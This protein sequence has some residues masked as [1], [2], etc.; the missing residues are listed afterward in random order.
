MHT[1]NKG[2]ARRAVAAITAPALL[3]VFFIAAGAPT[4]LTAVYEGSR[5]FA[6][7]ELTIAFG[8][9]SIALLL[10]LLVVGGISDFVGRRP[11]LIAAV[12]LEVAAMAMFLAT[13]SIVGLL[14]ARIVQGV[15]TAVASS[16]FSAA[17]VELL[18]ERR[19]KFGALLTSIVPTTGLGLGALFGGLAWAWSANAIVVAWTT[20]LVVFGV[21][22]VLTAITPETVRRRSGAIRS[23]VPRISV[24]SAV[25]RLFG[26]TVPTLIGAM[27]TIALFLGLIPIV[28]QSIFD[29]ENPLITGLAALT[30]FSAASLTSVATARVSPRTLR[31]VGSAIQVIAAVVFILSVVLDAFWLTWVAAAMQGV[32]LGSTFS[33]VTRGL[34]PEVEIHERAN[35]FTAIWLVVY[36]TLGGS[37]ILAGLLVT[38]IGSIVTAVG[39]GSVQAL[40]SAVGLALSLVAGK[41]SRAKEHRVVPPESAVGHKQSPQRSS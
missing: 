34:V 39:F 7:W 40:I 17:T 35:M 27:M 13:S 9:Y 24:P 33:G 28:F 19:K 30:A 31:R 26:I 20:L 29:I 25:R 41:R 23:L 11:I 15:A 36:L 18:P 14:V 5:G 10:T 6:P 2:T 16:S 3:T 37:A 21:G 32:A 8:L 12:V 4:P 1:E 22:L 38:P